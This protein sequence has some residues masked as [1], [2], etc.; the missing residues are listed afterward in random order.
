MRCY[1]AVAQITGEG[2]R[3][4]LDLQLHLEA[5]YGGLQLADALGGPH[6]GPRD[7]RSVSRVGSC[8]QLARR[9]TRGAGGTGVPGGQRRPA[10]AHHHRQRCEQRVSLHSAV[11]QVQPRTASGNPSNPSCGL[12]LSGRAQP[13][14]QIKE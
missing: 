10:Q 6:L 5:V 4:G 9:P 12:Q 7:T 8:L 1:C 2:A 11:T 13:V 3:V 14:R